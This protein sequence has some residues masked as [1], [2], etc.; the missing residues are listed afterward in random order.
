MSVYPD[1]DKVGQ[2]GAASEQRPRLL[3]RR[4]N[5]GT[6]GRRW[7]SRVARGR[8]IDPGPR[9]GPATVV[10][11]V[12]YPT[13]TGG[14]SCCSSWA[15]RRRWPRGTVRISSAPAIFVAPRTARTARPGCGRATRPCAHCCCRRPACR[16]YFCPHSGEWQI[17]NGADDV[18]CSALR[19]DLASATE[20]SAMSAGL[21]ALLDD[22][23]ALARAAAASVD[24][25]A[26]GAGRA[27]MKAAG[28]IVDD[29]AVTP[30]YVQGFEPE[31]ELPMIK[32]IARRL[33][34]QQAA[35]D[36][37]RRAAAQRAAAVAAHPAADDRRRL[38]LLRGR[39]EALG[40]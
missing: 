28:V 20:R 6:A 27:S 2:G 11:S 12:T 21:A 37:A 18:V 40:G 30:R 29:A 36:P 5:G 3:A 9:H 38:P 32:R 26:A 22:V 7:S 16:R 35:V 1:S 15:G 10:D 39:R 34:A 14:R 23:A 8:R 33:A 19:C 25:V 31:R 4:G 17:H 13:S 24:D